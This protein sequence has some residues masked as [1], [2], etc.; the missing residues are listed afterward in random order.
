MRVTLQLKA[1][2]ALFASV[3]AVN[4]DIRPASNIKYAAIAKLRSAHLLPAKGCKG[5]SISRTEIVVALHHAGPNLDPTSRGENI[6]SSAVIQVGYQ[7]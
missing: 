4:D 7:L 2:L 3:T 5:G 1:I 6:T